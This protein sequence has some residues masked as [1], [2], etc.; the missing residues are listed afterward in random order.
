MQTVSNRHRLHLNTNTNRDCCLPS[1]PCPLLRQDWTLYSLFKGTAQIITHL[2]YEKGGE[3][4]QK[5]IWEVVAEEYSVG[6][7]LLYMFEVCVNLC[8]LQKYKIIEKAFFKRTFFL[9]E[10]VYQLLTCPLMLLCPRADVF[11]AGLCIIVD[12]H[13]IMGAHF[14]VF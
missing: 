3:Q 5:M 6:Y 10:T 4:K 14:C 2:H 12:G 13:H 11:F 1:C 7:L 8:V 9:L